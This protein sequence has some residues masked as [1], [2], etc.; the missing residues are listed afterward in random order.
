MKLCALVPWPKVVVH[1]LKRPISAC[2]A[3]RLASV[4]FLPLP[5]RLESKWLA[6]ILLG[7]IRGHHD[8]YAVV[9][10]MM[11]VFGSPMG[12]HDTVKCCRVFSLHSVIVVW[13]DGGGHACASAPLPSVSLAAQL[14]TLHSSSILLPRSLLR[15]LA[16]RRSA[17]FACGLPPGEGSNIVLLAHSHHCKLAALGIFGIRGTHAEL[18]AQ[19][20]THW[21]TVYRQQQLDQDQSGAF[22]GVARFCSGFVQALVAMSRLWIRCE[23]PFH[24]IAAL[25][26]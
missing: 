15:S 7:Y 25:L 8:A 24:G 5:Q 2:F 14:S 26:Q 1:S 21:L 17:R 10:D 18:A 3:C 4:S 12:T 11:V 9:F 13:E 19:V 20:L 6:N 23:L 16:L 22:P